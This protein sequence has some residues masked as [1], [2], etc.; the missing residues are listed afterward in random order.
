M[1]GLSADPG[2]SGARSRYLASG[3]GPL[4]PPRTAVG[5]VYRWL[6]C[7]NRRRS[8]ELARKGGGCGVARWRRRPRPALGQGPYPWAQVAFMKRD[9]PDI[10]DPDPRHARCES[11]S[12]SAARRRM[13]P[14]PDPVG[15]PLGRP[16][17]RPHIDVRRDVLCLGESTAES[18]PRCGEAEEAKRR[19]AMKLGPSPRPPKAPSSARM[20]ASTGPFSPLTHPHPFVTLSGSNSA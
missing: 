7:P 1:T 15:P 8:D 4:S 16:T 3:S 10:S 18:G 14:S 6:P 5:G 13:D 17:P 19:P 11:T 9:T 12:P 2:T 20:A